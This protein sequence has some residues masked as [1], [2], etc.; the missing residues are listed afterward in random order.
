MIRVGQFFLD[1]QKENGMGATYERKLLLDSE[2]ERRLSEIDNRLESKFSSQ[3]KLPR[4][5]AMPGEKQYRD[6]LA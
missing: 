5:S 4:R 3:P 6:S 1:R 2:L